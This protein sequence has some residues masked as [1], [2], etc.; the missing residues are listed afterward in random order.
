MSKLAIL[1]LTTGFLCLAWTGRA[2]ASVT[3]TTVQG[4]VY[5]A[6]G[7]PGSGM[8]HV[9]WPAFTSP[10]GQA[11]VAGSADVTIG[12]DGFLSVN[13]APNQGAT[14]GGLY[15]TAIF[16]LND[17]S[18]STQYWVVPTAAQAT[19]AQ[20]QA[21]VMP[22]AQAVQTVSKAY[23]DQAIS[24]LGQ[25]MLSGS[26]GTLTGPLYLNGDPTQPLQAADKHYVDSLL[27]QAGSNNVNPGSPGQ[28]AYY[29]GNGTSVAGINIIPVTAGGTG[30]DTVQGGLKNLGGVSST[31]TTP[32]TMA[33][34][35]Y[36]TTAPFTCA[37]SFLSTA[38]NGDYGQAINAAVLAAP[39][40]TPSTI[41]ICAP[42]EHPVS[43]AIV[44]DRPINFDMT[45]SKLIPQAALASSPVTI[46]GASVTAGNRTVTVPST[47]GLSAGMRVGGV[48]VTYGSYISAIGAGNITLSLAPALYVTGLVTSGSDTVTGVSSLVGLAVGQTVTGWGIPA[49]TTIA[50]IGAANQTITLSNAA[51]ATVQSI[52]A[53]MGANA[54]AQFPVTLTVAGSWTTK[55]KAILPTPVIR[56]TWNAD[57]LHNEFGQMIGGAQ[58]GVWIADESNH[59]QTVRSVS[60]IQG[61]SFNGWDRFHSYDTTIEGIAGAAMTFA[62]PTTSNTN[63]TTRE[64]YFYNTQ[65]RYSGTT[66]TGQS[67]LELIS[68]YGGGQAMS[69]EL[70][71]L[72]FS[73]GH[74]VSSYGEALVV[75]T[76]NP[77]HTGSDGPRIIWFTDNFQ[78]ES[79]SYLSGRPTASTQFNSVHLIQANDLYLSG[80]AVNG[81][82]YGKSLI[83]MDKVGSVSVLNSRLIVSGQ[84]ESCTVSVTNGSPTVTLVSGCVG[85]ETDGSWNGVAV[86]IGGVNYWLSPTNGVPSSSTLTLTANYAGTTSASAAL[87]API[88]T[89]YVF[90]STGEIG[91]SITAVGNNIYAQ[92]YTGLL[93][94]LNQEQVWYVGQAFAGGVPG[95]R[96]NRYGSYTDNLLTNV[97]RVATPGDAP[98]LQGAFEIAPQL[99]AGHSYQK[100]FGVDLSNDNSLVQQFNYA[101]AG[102][103]SNQVSWGFFGNANK[104]SYFASGMFAVPFLNS[105]YGYMV[106]NVWVIPST[107]SGYHGAGGAKLQFSDGTGAP[108]HMATYDA[109]GSVTDG[110]VGAVLIA[111]G[112]LNLAT[113]SIASSACQEVTA[114]GV[115][116]A[117]AAGVLTTDT[118]VFTPAGSIKAVTGYAPA[119]N[120]GL[121]IT[122]YP[123]LGYVNFDVC[124][125]SGSS[126]TPGAVTLNW[127]VTR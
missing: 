50:A 99:A 117:A 81:A 16:Y 91:N 113:S 27:G 66:D 14:P 3:T 63:C 33:G 57:A 38:M 62:D 71:Q 121:G 122:A 82:G 52:N 29:A 68:C 114:G 86:E 64:S 23:V 48:G 45:G 109:G 95:T 12:Q 54:G 25:T 41:K 1:V 30:S 98:F 20:V 97:A 9:S 111:S 87:L 104:F 36:T 21:Q 124:N 70:N 43:T 112:T 42:G 84:S 59:G 123:T 72:S 4:T 49:S 53:G 116:S 44:I 22:A 37:E 69:D 102:N 76:Y 47:T 5:L 34:P 103:S 26:G 106:N 89:G 110:G 107:V 79:G 51:I 83:Q 35:L 126:I 105:S 120:G 108:G 58:S 56:W 74:L 31:S 92:T 2:R 75:G 19:L 60:G 32:Q 18:V 10:N 40:T 101:G 67:P 127:K 15:Y 7:Q 8:L 65:I 61:E 85:F 28:I 17:G 96:Q 100:F 13:L 93:G 46:T 6:N 115:N 55:L 78:I 77:A 118:I 73:G 24:Q 90:N 125:W 80:A 119:A 88:N 11:V 39:L 94:G